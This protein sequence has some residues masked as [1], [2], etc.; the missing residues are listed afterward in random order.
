[1]KLGKNI[2][3]VVIFMVCVLGLQACIL[4]E[5]VKKTD[6]VETVFN[7]A[8]TGLESQS[9]NWQATLLRLKTELVQEGQSTLAN[10]VQGVINRG[11][12]TASAEARCDYIFVKADFSYNLKV[13]LARYKKQTPPEPPPPHF[14]NIDPSAIDLRQTPD[15][16][17]ATLNI[18]GFNFTTGNVNVAVVDLNGSRRIPAPGFFTVST[19]FLAAFNIVNYP[20]SLTSSYV[21][22]NLPNGE[23]R[24]VAIIQAPTCGGL[25]EACCS[26]GRACNTGAGCL[27]GICKTCP[28]S[29]VPETTEYKR[30]SN[31]FV[32][33]NCTGQNVYKTYGGACSNGFHREQ[34]MVSVVNTCGNGCSANGYW[35]NSTNSRDC[36]CTVHYITPGDCFKHV[37]VDVII[38]Q[39]KD[40]AP[41][42]AGCP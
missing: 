4:D 29:T 25:G 23:E 24:R 2:I 6:T 13:I 26:V 3:Q 16:R 7:N 38:T 42:P 41:L 36:G 21:S 40:V 20:F 31:E 32:G 37:T 9:E 18:Y 33:N 19:D 28:P 14:C 5:I 12:S 10:E 15:Q 1:M 17:P 35:T 39:T 22:F 11:I 30:Y 34:C 27:N 8:L